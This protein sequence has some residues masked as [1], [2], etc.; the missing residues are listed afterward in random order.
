MQSPVRHAHR[1][2]LLVLVVLLA[3][4]A[5]VACLA[6]AGSASA[7]GAANAEAAVAIGA[8]L[9]GPSGLR[10]TVYTKGLRHV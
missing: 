2:P 10:A 6:C 1:A 8:G 7:A 3:L 4:V 5:C 9:R